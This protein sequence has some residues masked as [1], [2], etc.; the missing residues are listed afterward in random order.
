MNMTNIRMCTQLFTAS[1]SAAWAEA[2]RGS[3]SQLLMGCSVLRCRGRWSEAVFVDGR[4]RARG[5]QRPAA[6]Q[7]HHADAA[8]EQHVGKAEQEDDRQLGAL[9]H[10]VLGGAP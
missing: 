4:R 1:M 9:D 6:H 2:R 7:Q 5:A 3:P 10:R 8:A